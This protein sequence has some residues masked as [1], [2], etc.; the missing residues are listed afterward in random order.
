[1]LFCRKQIGNLVEWFS[2]KDKKTPKGK[3]QKA[4]GLMKEY[5]NQKEK[6]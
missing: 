4:I 1:L 5:Y 6:K 3:L 2:E